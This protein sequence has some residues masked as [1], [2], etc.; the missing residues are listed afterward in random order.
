M[1]GAYKLPYDYEKPKPTVKRVLF[2]GLLLYLVVGMFQGVA[3]R[4]HKYPGA[5][6]AFLPP[7]DY[8]MNEFNEY[9]H[10]MG[11][12][13]LSWIESYEEA[14]KWAT[15]HNTP[16]F[17]DFTGVTCVNCRRMEYEIFPD[18]QVRPLLKQF[19][20]GE[21]WVDKPPHGK[22]NTALQIERFQQIAQPFYAIIDPRDDKTLITFPGYDPDPQKFS[23]FLQA[24]LD[25]YNNK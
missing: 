9:G 2:A 11:A 12:A 21:L 17:I 5:V 18:D 23:E 24:G 6:L 25:A 20:R 13:H 16:L 22:F 10:K 4:D 14:F 8:G 1:L 19:T 7:A 15:E 3:D